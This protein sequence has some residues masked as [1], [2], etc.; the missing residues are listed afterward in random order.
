M[1]IPVFHEDSTARH[2]HD[3]G[4][5]TRGSW[6]VR[7]LKGEGWERACSAGIAASIHGRDGL[8]GATWCSANQGLI[9]RGVPKA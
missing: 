8:T 1:D 2:H 7:N 9:F 4:L 5:I 6:T 3:G